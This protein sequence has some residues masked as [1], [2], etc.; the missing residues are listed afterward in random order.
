M[1]TTTSA[2]AMYLSDARGNH[3]SWFAFH[4]RKALESLSHLADLSAQLDLPDEAEAI[5]LTDQFLF[6]LQNAL[7]HTLSLYSRTTGRTSSLRTDAEFLIET[8]YDGYLQ[9]M[10]QN[11]CEN[12]NKKDIP[13]PR[14]SSDEGDNLLNSLGITDEDLSDIYDPFWE[15]DLLWN[16][17]A[18]C[19]RR[20][21]LEFYKTALRIL[22]GMASTVHQIAQPYCEEGLPDTD[23]DEGDT[24]S[25]DAGDDLPDAGDDAS[26]SLARPPG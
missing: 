26:P 22:D 3:Q 19:F 2:P 6:Y 23:S 12:E 13:A 5:S 15:N 24:G 4:S 21:T 9:M 8:G 11:C 1:N 14:P 10:G 20:H 7:W 16:H 17:D 25:G 18:D